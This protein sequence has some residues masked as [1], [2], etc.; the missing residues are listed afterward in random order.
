MIWFD[1]VWFGCICL[2]RYSKARKGRERKEE[3]KTGCPTGPE[4]LRE[5]GLER[6]G[7]L[8]WRMED[9]GCREGGM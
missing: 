2:Y 3:N 6:L 8:D 9:V 4:D 5:L 1:L 7:L